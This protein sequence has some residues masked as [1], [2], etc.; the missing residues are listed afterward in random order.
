MF[1]FK[2]SIVEEYTHFFNSG[3]MMTVKLT[4]IAI[5]ERIFIGLFLALARISSKK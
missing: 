2:V 5:A 3:E 1:D 4:K